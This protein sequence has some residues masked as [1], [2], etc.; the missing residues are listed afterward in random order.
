MHVMNMEMTVRAAN[1]R[2]QKMTAEWLQ[3]ASSSLFHNLHL[4]LCSDI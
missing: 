4:K 1:V 3:N 2:E